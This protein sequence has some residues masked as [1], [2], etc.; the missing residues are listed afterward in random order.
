MKKKI[1]TALGCIALLCSCEP[2]NESNY[3]TG[4]VFL[5]A[6]WKDGNLETGRRPIS[7][8][9]CFIGIYSH[10]DNVD[11]VITNFPKDNAELELKQGV[12][13]FMVF[14]NTK[15]IKR[16]EMYKTAV[17]E[18]P[19]MYNEEKEQ[20]VVEN[21]NEMLYAGLALN[22]TVKNDI[23]TAFRVNVIRLLKKINFIVVVGDKKELTENIHMNIS[24]V[25]NRLK[26][27]NQKVDT[28]DE[29]VILFDLKKRGRHL[30]NENFLT[31]YQGSA[32]V[33][34][35]TGRNILYMTFTD[36]D[37]K[38]RLVKLNLTKYLS[39]WDTEEVTVR[40]FINVWDSNNA[41]VVIKGWE[42]GNTTDVIFD[43]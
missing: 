24:G 19:T 13:D 12:Y 30:N 16:T 27:W 7:I 18:L 1:F 2:M 3:W 26:I 35:I 41:D 32:Y 17:V 20:V 9:S 14:H 39:D 38:E 8:D 31:S 21:P 28:S 33:L 43:Y 37:G 4:N 6:D 34:G 23:R 5:H 22:D 29:A 42:L 36:G 40:M 25:A 11:G 15:Y 10:D